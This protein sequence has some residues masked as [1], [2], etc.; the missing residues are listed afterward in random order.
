MGDAL[1]VRQIQSGQLHA[2][3]ELVGKYQDRI[4]NTCWRICG[5]QEDARD[6]TQEV[7]LKALES[8]DGF[9]G[10]SAFYT[11]IYRIAVNMSL[12]HK[13]RARTRGTL[14]LS[15]DNNDDS[16]AADLLEMMGDPDAVDPAQ[17]SESRETNQRVAA[18]LLELDGEHRCVLVLRDVEG[19]AYQDI[20]DVLELAVGT[21]KSRI[22]RA[23][24]ALRKLMEGAPRRETA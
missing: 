2:F 21:V 19:L 13:R 6:L 11:W 23:R 22:F 3:T 4:F 16:Q 9:R 18:A 1:L 12:S 5:H 8:I 24:L 14:S 17:E 15:I 10:K 7:F 20:A